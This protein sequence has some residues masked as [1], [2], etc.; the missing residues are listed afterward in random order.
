[1]KSAAFLAAMKDGGFHP[2]YEATLAALMHPTLL[3]WCRWPF[4]GFA[5]SLV[6]DCV[7]GVA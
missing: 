2:P 4:V 6:C 7:F 3:C 5:H 1:M